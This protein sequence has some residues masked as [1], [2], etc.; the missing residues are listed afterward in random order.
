M[1][2]HEKVTINA[3]NKYCMLCIGNAFNLETSNKNERESLETAVFK[4]Q[5]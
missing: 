1:K 5:A 2:K 4:Q 3:L